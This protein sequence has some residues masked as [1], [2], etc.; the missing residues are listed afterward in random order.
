MC[1]GLEIAAVIGATASAAG[2]VKALTTDAPKAI[3]PAAARAE[4]DAKATRDANSRLALRSKAL[5][6][7]SLLTG[8]DTGKTTFGG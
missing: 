4:A 3:D 5:A 7:S 6:S 8:A 1:T 2:A